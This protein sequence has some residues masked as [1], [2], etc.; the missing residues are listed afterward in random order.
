MLSSKISLEALDTFM[1]KIPASKIVLFED[2]PDQAK[3][4]IASVKKKLKDDSSIVVFEPLPENP[5]DNQLYEDR[6]LAELSSSTYKNA[7]LFV[8]DRDLSRTKNYQGLSEAVVTKVAAL[9]GLPLC[10]Y[11]QGEADDVFNRQRQW[12]DAQIVL[13]SSNLDRMGAKIAILARGFQ[14]IRVSLKYLE[15]KGADSDKRTPATA[16]AFILGRPQLADKIA[17]Y[18]SGDQKM[19]AEIL[20][21]SKKSKFAEFKKRLPTIFGYWL[22]ESILRFP[23]L[24]LDAVAAS[25]YLDIS[26]TDFSKNKK[27]NGLFK[28]ALYK[29][30][31]SD[32]DDAHWWRS[33]LDEIL[34]GANCESGRAF[35]KKKLDIQASPCLDHGKRA[36]F[37]CMISKTP[38][39][40]AN[41]VGNI[42]WF[43]PGADLAR[44]RKDLYE[45]IGPW[46]GLY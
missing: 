35:V 25:S 12:G 26:Q 23:G 28:N 44:V 39:S 37:Y 6:L 27:I 34:T 32:P 20:P 45:E 43:P 18:A 13:D 38:V 29:G 22:Y 40:E 8:T 5:R 21:F 24:L 1:N 36:G 3:L 7:S 11:A 30:P 46:L 4:I 15:S 14:E 17:L 16:M 33:D 19:A 41:S 10:K 9:F 31:F 42:S 2:R